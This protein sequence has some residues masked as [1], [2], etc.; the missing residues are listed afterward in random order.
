MEREPVST[1]TQL[2]AMIARNVLLKKRMGKKTLAVSIICNITHSNYYILMLNN[3]QECVVPLWFLTIL[4]VIYLLLPN[5][6]YV[7]IQEES[8]DSPLNLL[9]TL[10][11]KT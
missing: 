6:N 9:L 2:K 4:I 3:A 8:A 1:F 5:P 11:N 10:S 7:A